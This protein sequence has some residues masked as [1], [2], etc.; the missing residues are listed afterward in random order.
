MSA[1]EIARIREQI[2]LECQAMAN[3]TQFSAVASHQSINKRYENLDQ[4]RERLTTLVGEQEAAKIVV[5][6]YRE[7]VG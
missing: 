5:G 1:S 2:E 7:Q 3:L 4:C 6:I